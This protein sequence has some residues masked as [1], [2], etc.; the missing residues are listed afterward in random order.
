LPF[1]VSFDAVLVDEDTAAGAMAVD[2]LGFLA[3]GTTEPEEVAV[4]LAETGA[5][6]KAAL[7]CE[8]ELELE[9]ADLDG[10]TLLLD[11]L[12]PDGAAFFPAALVAEGLAVAAFAATTC[13]AVVGATAIG[14]GIWTR[15]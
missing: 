14:V 5:D 11:L 9:L 1:T 12:V 6:T 7:L 15:A 8:L 3:A 4:T 10:E 2:L 13:F